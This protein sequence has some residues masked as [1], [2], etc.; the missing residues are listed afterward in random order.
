MAFA[1]A[2]RYCTVM[3]TA[4]RGPLLGSFGRSLVVI[5]IAAAASR[6]ARAEPA[7][8]D[9]THPDGTQPRPLRPTVTASADIPAPAAGATEWYGLPIVVSDVVSTGLVATGALTFSFENEGPV[10]AMLAG[11]GGYSLGGPIVHA[12][13]GEWIHSGMSLGLRAVPWLLWGAL[14][15]GVGDE[16]VGN[17]ALAGSALGAMIVDGTFI[18]VRQARRTEPT[19]TLQLSPTIDTARRGATISLAGTF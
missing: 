8:A 1:C 19:S 9:A 11:L 16:D 13:N 15:E 2:R 4:F 6:S 18:A 17:W 12:A 10:I 7:G 3:H 14:R 5:L